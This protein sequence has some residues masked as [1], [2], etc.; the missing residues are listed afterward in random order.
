MVLALAEL[1]RGKMRF[2]L[3]AGALALL[4]F[5]AL[6]LSTLGQTLLGFE[7]GALANN[8]AQV[9][10]YSATAHNNLRASRLDPAVV[11]R[12]AG[13]AG[14]AAAAG[15]GEADLTADADGR[16]TPLTLFGVAPGQPG[17]PAHLVAGRWPVVGEA[18]VDEADTSSGLR[19]GQTFTVRPGGVRLRVVGYVSGARLSAGPTAYT[20]L[21]Q[22]GD[23]L[24][25]GNPEAATVPLNLVAVQTAAGVS[26]ATVAERIRVG[27]AGVTAL[28]RTRAVAAIPGVA[29]I[30]QTFQLLIAITFAI[31]VLVVGFFFLIVTVQ[32]RRT[33]LALRAVGAS[34][35]HLTGGLLAQ[36][37]ILVTTGVA[38]ATGVLGAAAVTMPPSFPIRIQ[39]GLVA[40][41]LAAMLAC[42]TAAGALSVRRI[43]ALDPA[44]AASAR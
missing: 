30:G 29:L 23:V 4:V 17:T 3:L 22:W 13:V 37:A 34:T 40:G 19:I 6:F 42:S 39:P 15:M 35:G 10:V 14:V 28:D 38:A 44:T 36:V 20:G 25:A 18:V 24:R 7:T 41:I 26:P 2:G 27:V 32:K 12:V 11:A 16:V 9:F 43:A 1:R 33:L 21:T 5:L 31:A 8:S